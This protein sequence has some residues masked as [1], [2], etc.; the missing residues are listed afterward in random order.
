MASLQELVRIPAVQRSSNDEDDIV[1]HVRVT[2]VASDTRAIRIMHAK[3]SD[4]RHVFQEFAEGLD[5]IAAEEVELVD[6]HLCRLVRD[7]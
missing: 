2:A 3:G 5:G 1:N 6:E 7:G 4:A